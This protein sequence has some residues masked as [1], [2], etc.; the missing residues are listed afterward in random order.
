M[1]RSGKKA[2]ATSIRG[3]VFIDHWEKVNDRRKTRN[4]KR[5][6]GRNKKTKERE[7]KRERER[8]GGE[9][10][11]GSLPK[12]RNTRVTRTERLERAA[13]RLTS[14]HHPHHVARLRRPLFR[15]REFSKCN[16]GAKGVPRRL[17]SWE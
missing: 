4:D 12:R 5:R 13:K 1:I 7:G 2:L 9:D 15:Y 6:L 3:A 10:S 11:G 14:V 17:R 8:G 16:E